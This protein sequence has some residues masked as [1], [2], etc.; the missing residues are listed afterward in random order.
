MLTIKATAE[1][2]VEWARQCVE[3]SWTSLHSHTV[4]EVLE[5]LSDLLHPLSD[6]CPALR[7]PS[8][9]SVNRS[10]NTHCISSLKV[11]LLLSSCPYIIIINKKLKQ[12]KNKF[13]TTLIF[14]E[15]SMVI[16]T[17]V[18]NCKSSVGHLPDPHCRA[19]D[20]ILDA[21]SLVL[22]R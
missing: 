14:S 4:T 10:R 5:R 18:S 8:S 19:V 1:L 16:L 13:A 12:W 22:Q 11:L 17:G 21:N 7:M 15:C 20:T 2:R 9:S 3:C 6:H